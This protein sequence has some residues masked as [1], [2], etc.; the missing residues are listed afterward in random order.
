MRWQSG[1][2]C[3]VRYECWGTPLTQWSLR[4]SS[5]F[6]FLRSP[7]MFHCQRWVKVDPGLME[8]L[9]VN[10]VVNAREVLDGGTEEA[11]A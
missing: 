6:S 3:G 2:G 4:F 10:L 1:C 9:I 5:F 11:S 8:Q 7:L